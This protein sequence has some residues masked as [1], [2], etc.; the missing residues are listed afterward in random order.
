[1]ASDIL[2]GDENTSKPFLQCSCG[3]WQEGHP[4]GGWAPQ[5]FTSIF[6]LPPAVG[7]GELEFLILHLLSGVQEGMTTLCVP[8]FSRV[9][10]DMISLYV[11]FFRSSVGTYIVFNAVQVHN[12]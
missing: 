4:S 2:A 9:Q 1:L 10:K 7:G 11:S 8:F 12:S 6:C 5:E 3:G